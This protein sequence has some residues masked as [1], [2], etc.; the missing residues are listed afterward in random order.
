MG[1]D[2]VGV[3]SIGLHLKSAIVTTHPLDFNMHQNRDDESDDKSTAE[4]IQ[5]LLIASGF[6]IDKGIDHWPNNPSR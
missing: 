2:A 5:T 6:F 1:S 4:D 3:G